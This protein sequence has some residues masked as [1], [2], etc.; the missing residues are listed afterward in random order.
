MKKEKI[1]LL[2]LLCAAAACMLPAV[3]NAQ[4]QS[5]DSSSWLKIREVIVSATRTEKNP[6][7]VGRSITVI[8][9]EQIRN[10][11]ANSVAEVLSREEGI[12]V[13]GTGQTPGQLQ[14]LFMRGANSNQT[15][16]L[17]DGIKLSDASTTD[18]SIDLSELSLANIDLIEIVRGSHSTLYGSSAIGGVINIITKKGM[19]PGFHA[20]AGLSGG[21]LGAGTFSSAENLFLNYSAKNGF[22]LNASVFNQH[23]NGLDASVDSVTVPTTATAYSHYHRD[24]DGFTKTDLL[25]KAGYRSAKL[26]VFLSYKRVD[27]T[28]SIDG[29]AY[30]DDPAYTVDFSRNL[31]SWGAIYKPSPAWSISYNAGI[32]DSRRKAVD[33]SSLTDLSG[34]YNHNYLSGNYTGNSFTQELQASYKIKGLSAVFGGGGYMEKMSAQT[35]YYSPSYQAKQ[36]LDSLKIHVNSMSEFAHLDVDGSLINKDLKVIGLG[37]GIRNT[38]Y[39]L[40]GN[41]L[42]YEISP[43]LW[44][45]N[46]ALVYASWST[47]FNAPSLYQLYTPD[48]D[49]GSHITRG[50]PYLKP[51]ESNSMEFGFKQKVNAHVS[52]HVAYFKTVVKNSIDYVFLWDKNKP[53]DSL[54][55]LDYKGDSYVNIGTYTSQGIEMGFNSKL[56]EKVALGVNLSLVTGKLDYDPSNISNVHTQ[57]NQVQVYTS[58]AFINAKVQNY[59]IARRPSTANI[60]MSYF[61]RNFLTIRTDIRYTGQRN[62]VAY[63]ANLGPIGGLG[64][65][66]LGDYVLVDLAIRYQ[67]TKQFS[68]SIR[69]ENVFDEKYYEIYGYTTRGRSLYLNLRYAF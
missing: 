41:N 48:A 31:I 68:A 6:D 16:I 49:P 5:G 25:G 69:L 37:L 26:D 50:N 36:N 64:S 61:P 47:G 65:Q 32:S 55:Y 21:A 62:D 54:T 14:N 33:D 8:S 7:S 67:I 63:K 40:F 24:R 3:V 22:Y 1:K 2:T 29:E 38:N 12:Y 15:S 56:S 45:N 51:E 46:N 18:N 57:G 39:N 60:N 13:V 28:S 35:F 42:T 66:G 44:L 53:T 58:G 20:D 43:S 9:A 11:G 52:F 27:Q 10:S 59:N 30:R 34:H 4:N 23:C 17:M 19:S